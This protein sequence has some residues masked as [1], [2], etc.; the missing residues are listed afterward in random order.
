MNTCIELTERLSALAADYHRRGWTPA[1]SSNFSVRLTSDTVAMTISGR[2]K[3]YLTGDDFLQ[4]A[5][6]GRVIENP[7]QPSAEA[8]LHLAIYRQFDEA[9]CVLHTHSP[10][11]TLLS[12]V[13]ND[14]DHIRLEQ[15]ELLKAFPGIKTHDVSV[16]VPIFN[17]Q[18]DIRE[19]ATLVEATLPSMPVPAFILR[20][21]GVYVWGED[22][23]A[24]NRHLEALEFMLDCELNRLRICP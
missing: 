16:D 19:L 12:M 2:H 23:A 5:L 10:A 20:G 21:H 22:L 7:R 6:D 4:M 18:Q 24:A 3:G 17:N 14:A 15:Y 11:A 13:R 8:E 9:Q 1:T